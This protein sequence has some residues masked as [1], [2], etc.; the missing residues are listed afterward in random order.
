LE[1]L[2]HFLTLSFT[3]QKKTIQNVEKII[4]ADEVLR[5]KEAHLDELAPNKR[6]AFVSK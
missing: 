5:Q 1:K 3:N 2:G 6:H 4:I